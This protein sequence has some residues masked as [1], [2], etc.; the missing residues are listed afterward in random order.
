[1]IAILLLHVTVAPSS[2]STQKYTVRAALPFVFCAVYCCFCRGYGVRERR[3]LDHEGKIGETR[4]QLGHDVT[5][6]EVLELN[7]HISA[8]AADSHALEQLKFESLLHLFR[9]RMQWNH[10]KK[11]GGAL[12]VSITA[13]VTVFIVLYLLFAA[14]RIGPD[15]IPFT[16][17]GAVL[18]G[19]CT[20]YL[21][22]YC[23]ERKQLKGASLFPDEPAGDSGD[24][25]TEPLIGKSQKV[26]TRTCNGT[27]G[28]LT[29][30]QEAFHYSQDRFGMRT[31]FLLTKDLSSA[32]PEPEPEPQGKDEFRIMIDP[33]EHPRLRDREVDMYT[34]RG[35][36]LD[37][38][39][40]SISKEFGIQV[41]VGLP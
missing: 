14:E 33:T 41:R 22:I 3:S 15:M 19:I 38:L 21:I 1:V 32:E 11:N 8:R 7:G 40:R 28:G 10:L 2:L 27:A 35:E 18:A 30:L 25:L 24:V 26:A 9:K 31:S 13:A 39:K 12:V 5:R 23:T 34:L 37:E 20:Y 6:Q 36:S 17:V 4:L 16:G 29:G